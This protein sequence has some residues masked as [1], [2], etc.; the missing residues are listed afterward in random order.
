MGHK[1]T[2]QRQQSLLFVVQQRTAPEIKRSMREAIHFCAAHYHGKQATLA[3]EIDMSPS[4]FSACTILGEGDHVRSFPSEKIVKIE[5]ATGCLSPLYT[6]AALL[7][8]KVTPCESYAVEA[9][10]RLAPMLSKFEQIT[11]LLRAMEAAKGA[12]K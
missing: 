9:L 12:A 1:V 10:E 11:E 7:G 2:D 8:H 4:F 5:T 3:A 6:H